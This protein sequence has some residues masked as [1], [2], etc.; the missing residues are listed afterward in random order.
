MAMSKGD[1][2]EVVEGGKVGRCELFNGGGAGTDLIIEF[3][4]WAPRIRLGAFK[5][6]HTCRKFSFQIRALNHG[7]RYSMR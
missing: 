3:R 7:E 4:D 6:R 1:R 2:K 5:L